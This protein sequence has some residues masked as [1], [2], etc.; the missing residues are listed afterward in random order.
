M[1]FEFSFI[2]AFFHVYAKFISAG[3]GFAAAIILA[4]SDRLIPWGLRLPKNVRHPF[5]SKPAVN[6]MIN[7]STTSREEWWGEKLRIL[8]WVLLSISFSI[9][10][11]V[12]WP[13][14]A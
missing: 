5:K 6:N 2:E 1:C 9:Q 13:I 4:Y 14:K 8:G 7:Q 10:L 11:F 12:E 3:A